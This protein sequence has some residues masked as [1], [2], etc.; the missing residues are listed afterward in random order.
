VHLVVAKLTVVFGLKQIACRSALDRGEPKKN[1]PQSQIFNTPPQPRFRKKKAYRLSLALPSKSDRH[2]AMKAS[3]TASIDDAIQKPEELSRSTGSVVFSDT[4]S[5]P[6]PLRIPGLSLSPETTFDKIARTGQDKQ[7]DDSGSKKPA[8]LAEGGSSESSDDEHSGSEEESASSSSSG[9]ASSESEGDSS[10]ADASGESSGDDGDDDDN[11]DDDNDDDGNERVKTPKSTN[12]LKVRTSPDAKKASNQEGESCSGDG[13]GDGA[14]EG[15]SESEGDSESES[16]DSSESESDE[17]SSEDDKPPPPPKPKLALGLPASVLKGGAPPAPTAAPAATSVGAAKPLLSL[18]LPSSVIKGGAAASAADPS[19][20]GS[21]DSG[22]GS[23]NKGLS[24]P[25][26]G[27]DGA[28][29]S[30]SAGKGGMPIPKLKLTVELTKN[31]VQQSKTVDMDTSNT[32]VGA[33]SKLEQKLDKNDPKFQLVLNGGQKATEDLPT[34]KQD[35]MA[36]TQDYSRERSEHKLYQDK[37]VHITLLQLILTLMLTPIGT[38]EPLYSDQFPLNN[39]KHN[40]PFLLRMHL[41]HPLNRDIIPELAE[42]TCELGRTEF[43]LLKLL[44]TRL[45]QKDMYKN[46]MRL[47]IGAY[48]TVYRCRLVPEYQRMDVAIKLMPVPKNIHDRCVVHDIFT[49]ILILDRFK[50]D[51][52][53]SHTYDFGTDD[54]YYWIIMKRYKCS[55]KEWRRKQIAPLAQN[56]SLY[57]NVYMNVLN[58]FQFL[59]ENGVNHF[60]V[61]CDNFLIQPLNEDHWTLEDEE[62]FWRP[63]TDIPNFS[64]TLADFG[65]SKIYKDELDGYTTRN[66]GTEFTKSPEMLVVANASQKTRSTYDR[67]KKVWWASELIWTHSSH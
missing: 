39:K 56:L 27:G 64:V 35:T 45:F 46:L 54:E 40:V 55:L 12:A 66:R 58:T 50:R 59:T 28:K 14:E 63:T 25:L 53:V 52:R 24:L 20:A 65:E 10:D 3:R 42:A 47:A 38:L 51:T 5:K 11:D 19:S 17:S 26:V 8:A 9:A 43:S 15:S 22:S 6:T 61:K 32:T 34:K 33:F 13:D 62:E 29:D 37:E 23:G 18:G 57:L 31:R 4:V 16:D 21:S 41:N 44:C 67:R 2:S 49:E 48:G 60:D 7:L 30:G 1:R 36:I